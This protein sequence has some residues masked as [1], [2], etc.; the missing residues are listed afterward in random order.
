MS[1]Q[2]KYYIVLWSKPKISFGPPAHFV[3]LDLTNGLLPQLIVTKTMGQ[4]EE[5]VNYFH[6][7]TT[8]EN[9]EILPGIADSHNQ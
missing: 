1:L 6:L 9:K 8:S 3:L 2:K 7:G 5:R 4:V